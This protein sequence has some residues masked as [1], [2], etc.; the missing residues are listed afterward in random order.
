[1]KKTVAIGI[2]LVFLIGCSTALAAEKSWKPSKAIT[3][4]FQVAAGG[5]GDLEGKAMQKS[6]ETKLG[7]GIVSDYQTGAGGTIAM[8]KLQRAKSDGYTLLYINIP[9]IVVKQLT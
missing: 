9:A 4:L 7:V 2:A 1:M 8:L 5:S 3:I 6:L